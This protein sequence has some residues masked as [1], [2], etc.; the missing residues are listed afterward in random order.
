MRSSLLNPAIAVAIGLSLLA[1]AA[2]GA[3]IAVLGRFGVRIGVI[4]AVAFAST[5]GAIAAIAT[6]PLVRNGVSG[7]AT[8]F[9]VPRWM[10]MAGV[11]GPIFGVSV[12]FAGPRIGITPT[13]ALAIAGQVLI[14]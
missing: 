6:L 14:G 9:R 10:W 3:T 2:N 13:I 4:P 5:V 7:F 1:G 8:A 11:I 12:V